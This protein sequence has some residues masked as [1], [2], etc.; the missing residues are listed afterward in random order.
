MIL[1]NVSRILTKNTQRRKGIMKK[2]KWGVG[3]IALLVI[4]I[5]TMTICYGLFREHRE[6]LKNDL[7]LTMQAWIEKERGVVVKSNSPKIKQIY[8]FMVISNRELRKTSELDAFAV[9]NSG[10][11]E[12]LYFLCTDTPP[13]Q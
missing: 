5:L 10:A 11:G 2:N 12:N 13:V 6:I 1:L 8:K 3:F 7:G 4:F 9:S